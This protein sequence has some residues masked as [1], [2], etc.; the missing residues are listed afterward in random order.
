M[1][2]LGYKQSL[3]VPICRWCPTGYT[4]FCLF[5]FLLII[6]FPSNKPTR[7]YT[8]LWALPR[9]MGSFLILTSRDFSFFL[10]L[11]FNLQDLVHLLYEIVPFLTQKQLV[12]L[13]Q[14]NVFSINKINRVI[15]LVLSFVTCESYFITQ[16]PPVMLNYASE[17]FKQDSFSHLH[18]VVFGVGA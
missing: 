16:H 13:K 14:N 18:L 15:I 11:S 12:C 3:D 6:L 10:I 17:V 5:P 4:R 7:L 2:T 9:T 8:M 1:S